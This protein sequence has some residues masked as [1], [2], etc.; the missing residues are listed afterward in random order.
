MKVLATP[1]SFGQSDRTPI[2]ILENAG[3]EVILNPVGRILSEEEMTEW[4]ADVDG[5]VIGVDPLNASVLAAAKNLKAISKYGVGTDNIDLEKARE[6]GIPVTIT[7]GANADA[8]ADYA[9]ALMMACARKVTVID[10]KC[11]QKDWGKIPTIDIF[12]KKLG[13]LG[14]GAVGRGVARRAG[15]FDMEVLSYD[16][17]RNEDYERS[18]NIRFAQPDEIFKTCDFISIHLPLTDGTRNMIG[19]AEFKMMKPTAVFVN[20]ARGGIV[21]EAALVRALRSGTIYAA[22]VDAFSS[23]PPVDDELYRLDNLIMGSHCAASTAGATAAMGRMAAENLL[24]H[25]R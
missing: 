15:G 9:F 4:I 12:G 20:T 11:R 14:L 6:L 25:L 2:E 3:C 17:L 22:G 23:E 8:V 7:A 16:L 19:D 1:R 13:I 10:A 21:D 24:N 18:H 5:V